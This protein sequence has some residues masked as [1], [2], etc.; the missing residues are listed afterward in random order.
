MNW[1]QWTGLLLFLT[2]PSLSL[3][4]DARSF[5]IGGAAVGGSN[6]P[7]SVYW[8]PA[9]LAL[10]GAP[11][12]GW[13][14]STG[15]SAF[16]TSNSNSPILRFNSQAALGSSQDP[17]SQSLQDLGMVAVQYMDYGGGV[18]YDH[19]LNTVESH[20]AYQFFQDRQANTLAVTPYQLNEQQTVQDVET[21]ILSYSMPLPISTFQFLSAAFSL[22]Y[23][24]GTSF[25]QTSL[26]G[27]FT[28]GIGGS[29]T[30]TKT[31]S[32]SGLGLS[33]DLGF[34]GKLSDALQ[35]GVVVQNLTSSF[36]WS[37]Q[38]QSFNLDSTDG[39]ET[40]AG[41]ATNV[42]VAAPFP[43]TVKIGVLATPAGTDTILNG[44]VDFVN[45]KTHWKAGLE[46][47]YPANNLVVRL[48]TFNDDVSGDQLWTI[49]AGFYTARFNLDAAVAT[50][51]IPNVEDSVALG[52]SLS[53]SFRF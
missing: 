14:L 18:L 5:A 17:I 43:Y 21:L 44:E 36:N 33:T 39:H 38:Q 31:T 23:N 30:Y 41:P 42:T 11:G 26:N 16:N 32:T 49:G 27:T 50:R 34:I 48:G 29:P 25:S 53:G 2:T 52:G 15:Y 28:Q 4:Q 24:Y 3:A 8:N 35:V 37:A 40:A 47:Y 6:G 51:S 45:H 1:K 9:G 20:G 12:A 10:P 7:F 13:S 22:K 19:E 46:R